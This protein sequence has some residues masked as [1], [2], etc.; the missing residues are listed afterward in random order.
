MTNKSSTQSTNQPNQPI[1]AVVARRIQGFVS[2]YFEYV[3]MY[4]YMYVCTT[5]CMYMYVYQVLLIATLPRIPGMIY[6]V[7]FAY[8]HQHVFVLHIKPFFLLVD[9]FHEYGDGQKKG[10]ENKWDVD[11]KKECNVCMY[12]VS[13]AERVAAETKNRR[14]SRIPTRKRQDET[15]DVQMYDNTRQ[16]VVSYSYTQSGRKHM[17]NGAR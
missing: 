12:H 5:A 9:I 11:K 4:V 17:I 10:E 2:M 1:G 8:I 13:C 7:W 6:S 15:N 3:L 14:D 16:H